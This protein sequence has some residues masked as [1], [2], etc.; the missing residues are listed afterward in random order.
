[1]MSAEATWDCRT[2]F[3]RCGNPS[4]DQLVTVTVARIQGWMQH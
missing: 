4:I 1:M 2:E 3:F